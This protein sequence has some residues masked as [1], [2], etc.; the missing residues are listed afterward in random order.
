MPA[1]SA[2]RHSS[3]SA[4]GMSQAILSECA[5]CR[6]NGFLS[7]QV[8]GRIIDGQDLDQCE[9]CY[10][11]NECDGKQI[12]PTHRILRTLLTGT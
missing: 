11:E 7:P 4:K 6:E 9:P 8:R 2:A 3:V 10:V 12:S 5:S 1:L